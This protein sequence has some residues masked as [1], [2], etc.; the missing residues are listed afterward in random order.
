MC[1]SQ[2][3]QCNK[4]LLVCKSLNSSDGELFWPAGSDQGIRSPPRAA[5]PGAPACHA[6]TGSAAGHVCL[7]CT[8]ASYHHTGVHDTFIH[9]VRCLIFCIKDL[10]I[11]FSKRA[12]N[13]PCVQDF[14]YYNRHM[15]TPP[16]TCRPPVRLAKSLNLPGFPGL[17]LVELHRLK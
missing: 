2:I 5:L 10:H 15:R 16:I 8:H 14:R 6:L 17:G 11:C 1:Y 3:N 9:I 13:T 12:A 4:I 7:A